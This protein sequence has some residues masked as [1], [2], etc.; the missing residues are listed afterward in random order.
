MR[1][2]SIVFVCGLHRST[3]ALLAEALADHPEASNLGERPG[4]DDQQHLTESSELV[5]RAS[6]ARLLEEWGGRYDLGKPVVVERSPSNLLQVRFLQA[7]FPEAVFV[8]IIRHPIAVAQETANELGTAPTGNLQH[9]LTCH[10]LF[11]ADAP[12]ARRLIMVT[13][14]E[15]IADPSLV[16]RIQEAL[17]L[18][19]SGG[20]I[21]VGPD[22]NER[23]FE[24][25]RQGSRLRRRILTRRLER[26]ARPFGYSLVRPERRDLT[27]APEVEQLLNG[28]REIATDG[29]GKLR[30]F[31][32]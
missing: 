26:R 18:E 3:T 17:G 16:G 23:C 6:R 30:S 9:W 20:A 1:D 28:W 24:L 13:Y 21:K 25:W 5:T 4:C 22:E 12:Y 31:G 29:S 19:P 32:L 27:S 7:L 2:R 8:A 11:L 10:E 14:E 15:L